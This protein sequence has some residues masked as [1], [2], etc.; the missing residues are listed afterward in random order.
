MGPGEN[1]LSRDGA[2][3]VSGVAE[4]DRRSK[5]VPE[6]VVSPWE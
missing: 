6:C 5:V 3:G 4:V 2:V 1:P